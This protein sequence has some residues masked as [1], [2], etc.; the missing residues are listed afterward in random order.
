MGSSSGRAFSL[1][2]FRKINH[3][4]IAKAKCRIAT[5]RMRI[6]AALDGAAERTGYML[7]HPNFELSGSGVL[8]G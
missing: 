5:A 2:G 1:L 6:R 3:N 8:Q 4:K 7:I